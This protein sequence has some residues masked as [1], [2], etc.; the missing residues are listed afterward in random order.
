MPR[1]TATATVAVPHDRLRALLSRSQDWAWRAPH[2]LDVT[3][4]GSG[5]TSWQVLLNGSRCAWTLAERDDA[6]GALAFDQVEGDL[7]RMSGSWSLEPVDSGTRVRLHLSFDLGVDGLA[8][9]LDPIW[10][11]SLQAHA[12]ALLHALAAACDDTEEEP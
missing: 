6:S 7:E 10:S 1:L 11:Q 5:A 3:P 12:D 2:V 8:A 9:L 4:T